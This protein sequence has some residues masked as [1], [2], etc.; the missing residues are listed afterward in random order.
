MVQIR[1][2]ETK[3]IEDARSDRGRDAS[4][5]KVNLFGATADKENNEKFSAPPQ[6]GNQRNGVFQRPN[7]PPSTEWKGVTPPPGDMPEASAT[8]PA[9]L[10]PCPRFC[11]SW[12]C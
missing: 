11:A 3:G 1:E 8:A 10:V 12:R 5:L 4:R 7:P 2:V 9:H 6:G